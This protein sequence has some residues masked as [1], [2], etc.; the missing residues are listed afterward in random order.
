M[1]YAALTVPAALCALLL[2]ATCVLWVRSYAM[3]DDAYWYGERRVT[4][5]RTSGGG[6]WF[7]TRP[8]AFGTKPHTEWQRYR[9]KA[10]YPFAVS[11]SSPLH[12]RLGFLA[13]RPITTCC[14][15]LPT[16]PPHWC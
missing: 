8:W 1:R 9:D 10:L 4:R 15:P 16:G 7:E 12:E 13:P 6:F 3:T 2:L 11:P 14:S 5:Y